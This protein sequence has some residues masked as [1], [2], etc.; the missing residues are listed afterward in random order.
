MGGLAFGGQF[1]HDGNAPEI[2]IQILTPPGRGG[3]SGY[4]A[5][6]IYFAASQP[7]SART[8]TTCRWLKMTRGF[9]FFGATE[10]HSFA[11]SSPIA[12]W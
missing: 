11:A 12:S 8:G 5:G 10:N 2:Q 4:D 3:R 6:C 7:G 1:G 9:Y